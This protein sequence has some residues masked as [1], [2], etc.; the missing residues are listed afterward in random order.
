MSSIPANGEIVAAIVALALM[1]WLAVKFIQLNHKAW[2]SHFI[3]D[4][5]GGIV[6]IDDWGKK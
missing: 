4:K 2:R 5:N 3:E 1:V 6:H